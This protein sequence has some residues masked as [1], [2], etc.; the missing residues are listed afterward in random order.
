TARGYT[1]DRSKIGPLQ[2][3]VPIA[4]T[5]GQ[6]N[7]EWAHLLHKLAVRSPVLH[8]RWHSVDAPLCHPLF[9][10]RPGPV[11]PWER[12]APVDEDGSADAALHE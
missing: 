2:Q 8:A 10:V 6:V 12:V 9:S 11:E 3:V 5:S 7:H 4:V 1:F